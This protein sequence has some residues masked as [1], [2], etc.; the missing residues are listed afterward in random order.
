MYTKYNTPGKHP[1][2][3]PRTGKCSKNFPKLLHDDTKY[4]LNQGYAEPKRL[5]SVTSGRCVK[6]S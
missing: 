1:Y 5:T 2:T 4:A 3:D 6:L